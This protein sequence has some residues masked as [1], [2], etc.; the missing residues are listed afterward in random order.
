MPNDLRRITVSIR[1][2]DYQHLVALENQVSQSIGFNVG[3]SFVLRLIVRFLIRNN[4][5]VSKQVGYT[6]TD[7]SED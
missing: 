1:E 6:A 3:I 2:S 4:I 5:D 7:V